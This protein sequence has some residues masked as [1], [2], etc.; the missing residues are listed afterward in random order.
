MNDMSN[1]FLAALKENAVQPLA[2][3]VEQRLADIELALKHGYTHRQILDQLHREGI[4]LTADYYHRLITRLRTRAKAAKAKSHAL[5]VSRPSGPP[6]A[7][8][9]EAVDARPAVTKAPVIR[10]PPALAKTDDLSVAITPSAD[11]PTGTILVQPPPL[12]PFTWDPQAAKN[13]SLK[14]I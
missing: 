3:R 1:E 2:R 10:H 7:G 11:S 9:A 8:R 13:Y 6:G 4:T 12:I 14:D 5:L